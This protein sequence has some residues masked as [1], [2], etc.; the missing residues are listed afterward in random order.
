MR[1]MKIIT[2][3]LSPLNSDE[4]MAAIS[5]KQIEEIIQL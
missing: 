5:D 1:E 3:A 4:A 2:T